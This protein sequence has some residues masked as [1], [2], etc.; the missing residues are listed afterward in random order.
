MPCNN[1]LP[2][3]IGLKVE[4]QLDMVTGQILAL[5]LTLRE[6]FSLSLDTS[7]TATVFL[8]DNFFPPV[9]TLVAYGSS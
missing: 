6:I 7:M 9:A 2:E 3:W 8:I 1:F 4:Y 5:F